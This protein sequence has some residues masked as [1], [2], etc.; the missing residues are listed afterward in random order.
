MFSHLKTP[1]S[2]NIEVVL[3]SVG[4][5]DRGQD[6]PQSPS[7]R[8]WVSNLEEAS[9]AC[10]EYISQWNLG[11]GNW[12]GEAGSVF[13]NDNRVASICYNGKILGVEPALIANG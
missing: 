10:R 7:R 1:V 9:T 5:P 2:A 12:G 11:S 6:S 4:N 3:C 13:V 8:V